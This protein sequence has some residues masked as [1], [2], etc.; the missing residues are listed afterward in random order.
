MNPQ[1]AAALWGFYFSAGF[2]CMPY[3]VGA[4]SIFSYLTF[5]ADLTIIYLTRQPMGRCKLLD[6]AIN[7][8]RSK[9]SYPTKIQGGLLIFQIQNCYN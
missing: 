1:R 7:S 4:G 6:P 3:L 9:P 5:S 8:L 2:N